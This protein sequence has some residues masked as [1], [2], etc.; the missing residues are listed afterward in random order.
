MG[1]KNVIF[2]PN[3]NTAVFDDSNQIPELQKS[4]LLVFV[5]F[6][7]DRGIDPAGIEFTMPNR[8]T[9]RLFRNEDGWNWGFDDAPAQGGRPPDAAGKS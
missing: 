1:V 5:Q 9:V 4:W 7:E 3:G 6:L 8:L 2:F